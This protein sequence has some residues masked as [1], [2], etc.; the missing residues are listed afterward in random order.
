[1]WDRFTL[2]GMARHCHRGTRLATWTVAGAVRRELAQCCFVVE[3]A[4]GLPPK[5]HSLQAVFAPAWEPKGPSDHIGTGSKQAK[6][7]F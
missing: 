4:D 5:R 6:A 7:D 1:M 3:K 2:A